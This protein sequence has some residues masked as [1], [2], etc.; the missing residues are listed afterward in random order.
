MITLEIDDKGNYRY[1]LLSDDSQYEDLE[2]CVTPSEGVMSICQYETPDDADD[3]FQIVSMTPQM[4][5]ALYG[6]LKATI[7]EK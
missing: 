7:E 2:V 1:R 5:Y 3:E 6:V 4:A